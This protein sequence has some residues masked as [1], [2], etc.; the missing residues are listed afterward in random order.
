MTM[1]D[2]LRE[3]SRLGIHLEVCEDR[4][5]YR[6]PKGSMTPEL[7][8]A[9]VAH[10]TTLLPVVERLDAM[11]RLAVDAPRPIACARESAVGGPGQCFSCGDPL[12]HPAAY[13]R[14][15]PCDLAADAFY[16]AR[17][18]VDREAVA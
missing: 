12:E 18:R 17:A 9:L 2:V 16:S 3:T 4:L 13:G 8:A 6:A 5:R 14:C 11:R 10:K 15:M 1:Q 7:R